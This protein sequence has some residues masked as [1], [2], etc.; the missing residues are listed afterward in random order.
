MSKSKKNRLKKKNK[1]AIK[2]KTKKPKLEDMDE[3]VIDNLIL[4]IKLPQAVKVLLP[5]G[6]FIVTNHACKF[7]LNFLTV[8]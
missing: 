2:N 4:R 3:S 6:V 1:L 7:A 5:V 8:L